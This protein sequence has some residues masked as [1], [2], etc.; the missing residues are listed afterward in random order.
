MTPFYL[1]FG[2]MFIHIFKRNLN[3]KKLKKFYLLFL[4]LFFI[5]PT[6]YAVVSLTNDFKRTDYPG[7]EIARLIQKR[8]D[9]NFNNEINTVIGDEWY[10][11]NQWAK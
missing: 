9:D 5:S 11:G 2:M 6:T 4:L 7:K 10:A 8:W 3:Y 1:Y